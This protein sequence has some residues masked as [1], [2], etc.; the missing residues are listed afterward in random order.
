MECIRSDDQTVT[1]AKCSDNKPEE[2][3]FSANYTDCD[4]N[5]VGTTWEPQGAACGELVEETRT[6]EC[7][8]EDGELAE[9]DAQCVLPKIPATRQEM[10]YDTCS[11]EWQTGEWGD[12]NSQCSANAKRSRPISCIRED[13]ESAGLDRCSGQTAPEKDEF[14]AIYDNCG[15]DWSVGSWQTS[16]P[17]CSADVTRTRDVTCRRDDGTLADESLCTDAKPNTEEEVADYSGC[18]YAWKKVA[19]GAW[20]S[21]C[22]DNATRQATVTCQRSDGEIADDDFCEAETKP[23]SEFQSSNYSGCPS[24]IIYGEW[25]EWNSSCSA[26]ANRTRSVQCLQE[27]PSGDTAI[28]LEDCSET[29][30]PGSETS[31]IYSG[32]VAYWQE[33]AW[34]W[35][36]VEGSK[37]SQC[38]AEPKQTREIL[39][40]KT[41]AQGVLETI[42]DDQCP[43]PKPDTEQ[44]LLADYTGCGYTWV[45]GEWS[46]WDSTCSNNARR[47]RTVECHRT[48]GQVSGSN[49]CLEDDGPKPAT[50]EIGQNITDCGGK[51]TNNGFE[52]DL[53]GWSFIKQK[54]GPAVSITSDSAVGDKALHYIGNR[55]SYYGQPIGDI[56][57]DAKFSVSLRCKAP[58]RLPHKVHLLRSDG[59]SIADTEFRCNTTY[60]QVN[61]TLETKTIYGY[62]DVFFAIEAYSSRGSPNAAFTLHLDDIIVE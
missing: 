50:E 11:Y 20:S 40:K 29:P 47:T 52:S 26:N 25:T 41:N 54:N 12:W 62:N 57:A 15:Y 9:D 49:Y 7:K 55:D 48:D 43:Q 5:W 28:P 45:E 56:P 24:S 27:R 35:G 59:A 14:K 17:A 61:L 33:G 10:N 36:G 32:C 6:V 2:D 34:G 31:A 42:P 1:D 16:G 46:N 58:F 53:A 4:Y 21:T 18:T 3:E 23:S 19:T 51:L 13:G 60:E 8:R 30:E 38:S 39:C 44:T 37:S 22:S